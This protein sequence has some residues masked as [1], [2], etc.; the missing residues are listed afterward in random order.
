MYIPQTHTHPV[1]EAL[2]VSTEGALWRKGPNVHFVD[3]MGGSPL[4]RNGV[5]VGADHCKLALVLVLVYQ[6]Y[7]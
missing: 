3:G 2:N 4:P 6:Y 5:C 1:L 7:Y